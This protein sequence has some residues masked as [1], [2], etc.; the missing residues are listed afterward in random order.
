MGH[1]LHKLG[2]EQ[3]CTHPFR[4]YIVGNRSFEPLYRTREAFSQTQAFS[5]IPQL[6]FYGRQVS[7]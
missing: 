7:R 4:S 1:F 2:T 5:T 6:L 3:T